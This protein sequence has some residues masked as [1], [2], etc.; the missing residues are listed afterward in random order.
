VKSP[1]FQFYSN[2]FLGGRVATY[3]LEEIGLYSVLLAFDWSLTGLPIDDEKLAK[4]ARVSVRKFRKLWQSVGENF[5]EREG[6][7]YNP[8]LELERAKQEDNRAK[9]AAAAHS[10]WNA[11]ADANALHVQCSPSPTP[12]PTPEKQ[13]SSSAPASFDAVVALLAR[14]P[15]A[16]RPSWRAEITAAQTGMHGPPL[17]AEQVQTA[18]RDYLG[19]ENEGQ[20]SL[21]HFRGY[22]RS[23]GRPKDERPATIPRG[24]DSDA[25]RVFAAI[26]R[27]ET[28]TPNPGRGVIRS[29][30][31]TDVAKLGPVALAAYE[32]VGG[33]DRF[34]AATGET[35][36][37]LLRDFEKA[38]RAAVQ[39][40]H[41]GAA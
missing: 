7:Y 20:R 21:R 8:R 14:I 13:S 33:A 38:Y 39:P 25:G 24:E 29:I 18:C 17:T 30:P 6:R 23:I 37:F 35:V 19:N 10:R 2:D 5:V 26:R 11:H 40:S 27:L 9:R 1:A 15:E 12:S 22:L 3:S 28:S 16:S 36:G 34:L 32:Q 31:K 4:L 41:A